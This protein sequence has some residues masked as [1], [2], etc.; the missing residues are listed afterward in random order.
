M[1]Y[2]IYNNI[3][4]DCNTFS[5][6]SIVSDKFN[7]NNVCDFFDGN[8]QAQLKSQGF[9]FNGSGFDTSLIFNDYN[10][11]RP[12]PFWWMQSFAQKQTSPLLTS[13]RNGVHVGRYFK[14]YH[15]NASGLQAISEDFID[16]EIVNDYIQVIPPN[17]SGQLRTLEYTTNDE[18][19]SKLIVNMENGYDA[20]GGITGYIY[21][22]D[23]VPPNEKS[24]SNTG[25][26]L[27]NQYF[28][29]G[30]VS[31]GIPFSFDNYWYLVIGAPQF[32]QGDPYIIKGTA[33]E[34]WIGVA[35]SGNKLASLSNTD[36]NLK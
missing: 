19:L 6:G 25:L 28:P 3:Y 5:H 7:Y 26:V 29:L 1:T 33:N 30:V 17:T 36:I 18:L 4:E 10:E 15:I 9:N 34:D 32:N 14:S 13:G 35:N 31:S 24:S 22:R 27:S 12:Q 23:N 20:N 16:L 2:G 8:T 21:S 11:L